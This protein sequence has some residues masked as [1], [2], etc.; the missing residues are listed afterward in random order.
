MAVVMMFRVASMDPT[1]LLAGAG[2]AGVGGG[3]GAQSFVGDLV[4]GFFILFENL[5]LVGDL[6]RSAT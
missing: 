2:V 5:F 4:A 6:A 1:P 3:L